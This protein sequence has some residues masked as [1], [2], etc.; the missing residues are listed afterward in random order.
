MRSYL[1]PEEIAQQLK[2]GLVEITSLVEQGKLKA[3][4]IGSSI[5][6]PETELERLLVTC[7]AVATDDSADLPIHATE[8]LPEGSRW[9]FTRTK[10]AR[11]RVSGSVAEGADV[12]RAECSI[13][14][15]FLDS[16]WR[17]RWQTFAIRRFPWAASSTMP[18]TAAWGNSSSRSSRPR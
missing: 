18:Y 1:T 6:I 13:Q 17:R 16:L 15:S 7:A 3:I 11:F 10:R 5:R 14:S 9:C 12:C 4:R 2:V 8:I